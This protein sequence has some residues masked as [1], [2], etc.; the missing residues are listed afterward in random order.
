MST[1]LDPPDRAA[2]AEIARR[3]VGGS[4]GRPVRLEI[5]HLLVLLGPHIWPIL[6]RAESEELRAR[7]PGPSRENR[8][9]Q[10]PHDLPPR[11]SSSG[12]IG[13]GTAPTATA[14]ASA[15]T[16]T[17]RTVEAEERAAARRAS[18]AVTRI[19]RRQQSSMH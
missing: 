18:E 1:T 19:T 10:L 3:R 13:C 2:L 14:G 4:R 6:S 7:C 15:G 5:D 12:H 17:E 8:A 16:M 9:P 11:E